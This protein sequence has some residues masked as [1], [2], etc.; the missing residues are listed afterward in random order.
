MV[1]VVCFLFDF[2]RARRCVRD[3]VQYHGMRRSGMLAGADALDGPRRIWDSMR[4]NVSQ[5]RR[6]ME[7][8]VVY[9][10]EYLRGMLQV[11]I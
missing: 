8:K 2:G 10:P 6:P 7:I 4:G 5:D 1:C 3:A 9:S 11:G